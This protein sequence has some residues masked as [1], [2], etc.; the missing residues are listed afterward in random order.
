MVS[1]AIRPSALVAAMAFF[2]FP[3]V[4]GR[5]FMPAMTLLPGLT[6]LRVDH[7][8]SLVELAIWV[9]GHGLFVTIKLSYAHFPL[10]NT[11]PANHILFVL[12]PS[13]HP[14]E[15]IVS[16]FYHISKT[17]QNGLQNNWLL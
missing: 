16:W 4:T 14:P 9:D 10:L 12:G 11:E 13:T 6:V 17:R 1:L 3:V 7:Q 15:A 5:S 2:L 8:V